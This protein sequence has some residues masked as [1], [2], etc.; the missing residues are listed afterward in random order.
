MNHLIV[1]K[2]QTLVNYN[3]TNVNLCNIAECKISVFLRSALLVLI[4]DSDDILE[5]GLGFNPQLV[6][7]P[8]E[9]EYK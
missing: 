5:R 7:C 3:I 1:A 2:I 6:V 4:L 9:D 8:K